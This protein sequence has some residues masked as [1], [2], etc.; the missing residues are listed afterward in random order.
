MVGSLALVGVLVGAREGALLEMNG[1]FVGRSDGDNVGVTAGDR[2]GLSLGAALG[3]LEGWVV[4]VSEGYFVGAVVGWT[5]GDVERTPVGAS[6]ARGFEGRA[7][8]AL[9][10]EMMGTRVAP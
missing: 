8:G 1:M 4:G 7:V 6:A 3:S 2:D 10:G 9:L 5:E